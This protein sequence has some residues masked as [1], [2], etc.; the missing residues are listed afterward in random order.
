MALSARRARTRKAGRAPSAR[1]TAI[2]WRRAVALTSIKLARLAHAISSSSATAAISIQS[3]RLKLPVSASRYCTTVT[4]FLRAY[5]SGNSSCRRRPMASRSA[6]TCAPPAPARARAM[7]RTKLVDS[8]LWRQGSCSGASGIARSMSASGNRKERSSTPTTVKG[9][10]FSMT[11][12][13]TVPGS[14]PNRRCQRPCESTTTFSCPGKS[15]VGH[16]GATERGSH[17]QHL[18]EVARDSQARNPVGRRLAGEVAAPVREA[19]ERLERL[20]AVAVVAELGKR[21]GIAV[22]RGVPRPHP[23]QPVR[24][25][26]GERLQEH[27]VHDAEQGGIRPDRERQAGERDQREAGGVG[28]PTD[29]VAGV[30]EQAGHRAIPLSMPNASTSAR[31]RERSLFS[32]RY[33]R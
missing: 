22:G 12:R 7:A 5:V 18:E 28:E 27:G 15:S 17:S 11:V 3:A 9:S 29:G 25:R 6:V 26:E 10:P 31:M 2:S 23:V 4:P 16:Q 33:M 21:E 13:P 24:L 8:R 1:R 20:V 32:S 14:P 30:L 19:R